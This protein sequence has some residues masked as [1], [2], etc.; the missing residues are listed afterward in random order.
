MATFNTAFGSLPTPEK[1]LFGN[2]A[3]S[4][5]SG[6][7]KTGQIEQGAAPGST[8]NFAD[9]QK[10]G[11]ARPAPP[12]MQTQ[13]PPMLTSL[14]EQLKQPVAAP[15]PT[16]QVS[17]APDVPPMISALQTTLPQPTSTAPVPAAAPAPAVDA[18]TATGVAP[19]AAPV[20]ALPAAST[21]PPPAGPA[22]P[23][24]EETPVV[25]PPNFKAGTTPP[26]DAPNGSTFTAA[27]GVV[28][29]KRGG[30]WGAGGDL[31]G[32]QGLQPAELAGQTD[33]GGGG[34]RA[35]ID[36]HMRSYGIPETPEEWAALAAAGGMSVDALKAF[37][38]SNAAGP[39]AMRYSSQS[40]TQG[41]NELMDP[42]G[43]AQAWFNDPANADIRWEYTYVPK[44][45]RKEGDP[46]VRLKTEAELRAEGKWFQSSRAFDKDGRIVGFDY[47]TLGGGGSG[48]GGGGT[49]GGGT[50]GGG[51]TGGGYTGGGTP[52][53]VSYQ[54]TGTGTAGLP[55][56]NGLLARLNGTLATGGGTP[57]FAGS[58]QALAL[59]QQ[60]EA[61]LAKLAGGDD[62]QRRAFEATRAARGAE[63]AAQYGAERSKLEE[64]L[65]A[66]G[67]SASTI[68]GGRYGDLAGQQA[69]ATA[70]FEAEMLKQ[71]SEA[72]ARDRA[73][74]MSTMSD[75]AGMAGTQDLGAY[76]ANLKT[77]QIEADIGFRA[78]E[79]QQEAALRGRDLS[80]QEARDR[81]TAQYQ[82][83]QLG[84]GYAE[85][86]SREQM[87]REEQTFRA[88]ES[89]LERDIRLRLQGN[90]IR[91]QEEIAKL[92]RGLRDKIASG[93][94]TLSQG[95]ALGNISQ[96]IYDGTLPLEAWDT[97]LAALG[98]DPKKYPRPQVRASGDSGSD[99]GSA[100][101]GVVGG[102]GAGGKKGPLK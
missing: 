11:I 54:P 88:G 55:D 62:A 21:T 6:A 50:T 33:A 7:K 57:A 69:R 30:V 61:Q 36:Y 4:R 15:A 58:P 94:L 53:T 86:R 91:S 24:V 3:A 14:G 56:I 40:Q 32:Y 49:T 95:I 63:L 87:Q 25:N 71:Q 48:T 84:L 74:Y 93:E 26:P 27:D 17:T 43:E 38:A 83:G 96:R 65:A 64:D 73:L 9:M 90:E 85:M 68:G 5:R 28:W 37:V 92:D 98:L 80:L 52:G 75:L 102:T 78:A 41:Y 34:S 67:L 97:L 42:N 99:S 29:T 76:E 23:D 60:L 101:G 19:T 66:R 31:R 100:S 12:A 77:K 82:S 22:G 89:Q 8:M 18:P 72:E 13:Q 35:D 46:P 44:K 10:N 39:A 16:P 51:Y 45:D 20:G 47:S 1:E 81:A 70:T 79:L 59:R 2:G